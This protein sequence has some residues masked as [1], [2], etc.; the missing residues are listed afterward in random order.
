MLPVTVS[1]GRPSRAELLALLGCGVL[2]ASAV[3]WVHT[4]ARPSPGPP[5][6]L[7]AEPAAL[8]ITSIPSGATVLIDGQPAGATP[9][10]VDVVAGTH[11]VVLQ[12]PDAIDEKHTLEVDPAGASLA[13]S[14]WRAHP[15]ITYLKPPLPG[16]TLSAASFLTDGRLVLQVSLPDGERQ[17]WTLDPDA[18]LSTQRLGDIASPAP[19]A[20]RPDGQM[21]ATL[22]PG[23]ETAGPSSSSV[24]FSDHVPSG[25]VWLTS[26]SAGAGQRHVWT[27]SESNED[28]VDLEWAPDGQ[29][30]IVV[31]RQLVN[32]GAARNAIHWLDFTAG[33]AQ[34]LALLPSAVAP[35]TYVWSPDGQTVGFVVHTASLAA[36]CTLS[37]AGEFHYLGDLGP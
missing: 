16:A 15:S 8:E 6:E 9:A 33:E 35:G 17:A 27:V 2:V 11:E 1:F 37:V 23:P 25:E 36:V 31:G 22:K 12:A 20:I 18:H 19:L 28:L 7:P 10:T 24:L 29:H 5:A 3:A 34:D 4:A 21:A 32:G 14:L 30:L 13:I 26:T